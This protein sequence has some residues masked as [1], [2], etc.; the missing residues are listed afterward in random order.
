MTEIE[1]V[2]YV[3]EFVNSHDGYPIV[4]I[5]AVITAEKLE[6]AVKLIQRN[7]NLTLKEFKDKLGIDEE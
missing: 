7:S 3:R 4:W 2:A 1:K 5:L 6:S